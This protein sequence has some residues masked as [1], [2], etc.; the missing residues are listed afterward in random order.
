MSKNLLLSVFAVA[1][2]GLSLTSCNPSDK[3]STSVTPGK[4]ITWSG[5]DVTITIPPVTDL[6]QHDVIGTGTF[7]Y[8]LDSFLRKKTGDLF[9]M[10]NIDKFTFSSCKLTI[11]NPDAANN[12]QNFENAKASFFTSVNTTVA[13]M[14]EIANNPNTY[15]A[16]LNLPISNTDNIRTYL[17][18]SGPVTVTYNLGGKMRAVTN[19]TLT[20]TAHIEYNIHV[21]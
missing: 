10:K 15:A 2:L 7:T 3:N 8:D 19:T 6:N 12:F 5:V 13:N 17:P 9:G 20:V 16:E 11:T 4:D 1:A 21:Q 14:C 18:D